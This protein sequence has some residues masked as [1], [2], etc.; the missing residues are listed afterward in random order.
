MKRPAVCPIC[1][2]EFLADRATQKYCSSYCRRYAHRHGANNHVRPPKDAE[3]L[4]SFHCIKCGRLVRVTEPTDRR[5]KF[6]SAHCER[7][8]WKHS[9]K[10]TSVVIRRSF[11]CRHCGVLVEV[12]EAKDRRTTFCSLTCREK[13][14]SLH[15][16]K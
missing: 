12:S 4:R 5:T 3:A 1:G 9:K 14:F 6:C 15:R 8:Y 11:H 7:L 10:V 2:K 16:K 13:W